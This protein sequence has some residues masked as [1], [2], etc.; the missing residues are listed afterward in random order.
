MKY[1][2]GV[3]VLLYAVVAFSGWE[4][5]TRSQRGQVAGVRGGGVRTWTGGFMGGK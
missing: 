1:I 5:F 4:P 3:I 2:G